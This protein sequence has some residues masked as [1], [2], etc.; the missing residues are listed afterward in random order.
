[1]KRV[2]QKDHWHKLYLATYGKYLVMAAVQLIGNSGVYANFWMEEEWSAKLDQEMI[3]K[4]ISQS[5][6][7]T[8]LALDGDWSRPYVN[9]VLGEVSDCYLAS[10]VES[11]EIER[12]G[13]PT[14]V[15]GDE[16]KQRQWF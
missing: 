14:A 2:S 1:M 9:D 4:H 13:M 5:T 10:V 12:L 16:E 15:I 6:I 8:R 3:H 7:E 11:K